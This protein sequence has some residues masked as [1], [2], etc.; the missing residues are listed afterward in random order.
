MI[1]IKLKYKNM[2]ENISIEPNKSIGD[3]VEKALS[4]FNSFIFSMEDIYFHYENNE[5]IKLGRDT[6][7]VFSNKISDIIDD[8]NICK[9]IVFLERKRDIHNNVIPNSLPELYDNYQQLKRDEEMARSLNNRYERL[10]NIYTNILQTFGSIS[11]PPNT[12][13]PDTAQLDT[14]QTAQADTSQTD[15]AQPDTNQTDS[16]VNNHPESSTSNSGTTTTQ[17]IQPSIETFMNN[18]QESWMNN[19]NN[20]SN[21]TFTTMPVQLESNVETIASSTL[22]DLSTNI[23]NSLSTGN[24]TNTPNLLNSI[25][26]SIGAGLNTSNHQHNDVRVTMQGDENKAL[27][28]IKYKDITAQYCSTHSIVKTTDCTICLEN[29]Q[30]EDDILITGCKHLFH[31]KCA[32]QWLNNYSVKCPIC[33]KK[34]VKGAAQLGSS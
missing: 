30:N 4:K 14:S 11:N 10:D 18:I 20:N 6:N 31:K 8:S 3:L 1:S 12:T 26:D 23:I 7:A 33:K 2:E 15:T 29:F 9:M 28:Y 32:E 5:Y 25:L 22:T 16:T 21:I 27:T 24:T 19:M 34:I 13:A 17:S